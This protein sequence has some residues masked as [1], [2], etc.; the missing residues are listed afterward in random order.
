[1]IDSAVDKKT[2]ETI[3]R[4]LKRN[5]LTIEEIAEDNDV[6]VEIVLSIQKGLE[7][8]QNK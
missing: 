3:N 7:R 5:K 6:S 8:E 4:L 1:V 2:K